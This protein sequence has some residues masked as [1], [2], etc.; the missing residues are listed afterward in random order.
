MDARKQ[1]KTAKV[2]DSKDIICSYLK[3]RNIDDFKMTGILK[4]DGRLIN[5]SFL[6]KD[7]NLMITYW[8]LDE[9]ES[10]IQQPGH[11]RIYFEKHEKQWKNLC[12]KYIQAGG[13]IYPITSADENEILA[14]LTLCSELNG[15]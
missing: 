12:N 4:I 2:K 6:L 7:R 15:G 8:D 14:K 5:V 10:L 11:Y 3:S 13:T 1:V 9:V